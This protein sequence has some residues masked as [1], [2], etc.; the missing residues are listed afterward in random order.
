M[1]RSHRHAALPYV[2]LAQRGG[3]TGQG[4]YDMVRR[5]AEQAGLDLRPHRFRHYF[6]HAWLAAGGSEGGLRALGGWRSDVMR[7]Y[8]ASLAS[9]RA[10][11]EHGRLT[12]GDRI[13]LLCDALSIV[14]RGDLVAIWLRKAAGMGIRVIPVLVA[15][16]A[17]V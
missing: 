2:F 8:G 13:L 6:A 14:C 10:F 4:I 17:C 5:R 9:E 16:T 12:P 3:I 11:E 15:A 7:K 1:R